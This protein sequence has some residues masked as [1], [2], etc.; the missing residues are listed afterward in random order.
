MRIT[1]LETLQFKAYPRLLFVRLHTD[2]GLTGTG[3]TVDKIPGTLG[4]LHGT[5]APLL[6]GQEALEIE[7]N[8]R[9]IFDNLMY[10]G[11]SGA[12]LRA[13]SAVELAMWDL[14]GK[15]YQ[16][17][18]YHLLGGRSRGRV[19]TYNTCIGTPE[20]DDYRP[21]HDPDGDAGALARNL[22]QDGIRAMKIWPFDPFSEESNGQYISLRQIEQGLRPVRQ[23]RD[24]VGDDMEI[25]IECHFRWNRAS[26]ERI[27]KGLEPYHVLF[28]EDSQPAVNV[29]ELRLFAARTAIPV[30]GSE[31]L[32]TR[33][34][35]REWLEKHVSH[36]LMTDPVWNG[37]I[38]ETRKIA[39]MAEAFGIPVILHNV[40]G[41]FCQAACLHLG[42]HL[43]NL[44]FVESVRAFYR[45][46]FPILS[47]Y[48]PAVE[49]GHFRLLDGPGLGVGLREDVYQRDDLSR[50]VSEGPGLAA[51]RRAMGDHWEREEIR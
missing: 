12:E 8:W 32:M 41:P 33:W 20:V 6:L 5:I 45:T 10:H 35:V 48:A 22:L 1:R 2:S 4:A 13:L 25:G 37:G 17:P 46:Y 51:G 9:F 28:I 7:G 3:E 18:L 11:Y 44:A 50:Q 26:A 31:L 40:A 36:Y 30:V 19:P 27:A 39:S 14:L 47:D 16:A 23:I 15:A 29:D 43:P 49:D 34:Q 38:A 21:W 24:A 42:A